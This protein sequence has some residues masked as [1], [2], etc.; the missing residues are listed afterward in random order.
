M[1]ADRLREIAK[2]LIPPSR[3]RLQGGGNTGASDK[4][5]F[6]AIVYVLVSD[7]AWCRLPPASAYQSTAHR[8][9]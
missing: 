3:A 5:Q 7:C 4:G 2:P 6:A 1:D 9:S 8:R